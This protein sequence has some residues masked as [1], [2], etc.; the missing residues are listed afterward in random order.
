M[1]SVN[2]YALP[3][4]ALFSLPHL[5][6]PCC[7]H[8]VFTEKVLEEWFQYIASEKKKQRENS[9]QKI[10]HVRNCLAFIAAPNTPSMDLKCLWNTCHDRLKAVTNG[11]RTCGW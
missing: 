2:H 4:L 10:S 9:R 3:Y 5:N 11:R 1:V 8:T 7:S 6:L